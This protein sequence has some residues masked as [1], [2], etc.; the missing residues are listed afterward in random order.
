MSTI[1][2]QLL[3]ARHEFYSHYA[4]LGA[5][6]LHMLETIAGAEMGENEP[7]TITE[8]MEMEAVGAPAT[9]HRCIAR[10][11]DAELVKTVQTADDRRTKYLYLTSA[12]RRYIARLE[13]NLR[14]ALP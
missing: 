12:G 14:K 1:I 10:L 4:S 6:E 7:L 5:R 11:I 13:A 2:H 3:A 8:A 9:N